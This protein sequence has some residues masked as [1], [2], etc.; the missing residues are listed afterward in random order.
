MSKDT[1]DPPDYRGAAEETARADQAAL[2]YQTRANRPTQNTPFGSS[3]WR[4]DAAGNWTQD[5]TL[6]PSAQRSLD[7]QQEIQRQRSGMALNLMDRSQQEFG[8]TMDWDKFDSYMNVNTDTNAVRKAQEDALY[9]KATSRLDPRFAQKRES[10]EAALR[11]QGLRPGDEAYDRAMANLGR[12]ETDAYGQASLDA[13]LHGGA[14]AQR[15]QDMNTQAAGFN[16][17]LRQAKI[18]E[19]MQ[20]R[21][22]SLNEINAILSGQQVGMPSTPGFAQAGRAQGADYTGAARDDYGARM[23]KFNAEQAFI[24]SL[25]SG[26]SNMAMGWGGA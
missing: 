17:T 20:R 15:T 1:P 22:F 8:D 10:T 19:E 7:D 21:G 13:A 3:T 26:A 24:N 4:Q 11:N 23:D 12:E 18:G 2:E 14:E 25:M 9:G 6:D 5:I 16:N